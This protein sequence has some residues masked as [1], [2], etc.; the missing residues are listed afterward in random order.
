M[1]Q[2]ATRPCQIRLET[3]KIVTLK[4]GDVIDYAE[5]HPH[6]RPISTAT[7]AVDA[8][9]TDFETAGEDELFEAEYDLEELKHYIKSRYDVPVR[10]KSKKKLIEKLLDCRFRDL[11]VADRQPVAE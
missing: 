3:E 1:K 11:T 6:L 5:E 10:V 7:V 9:Y 4:L 8:A 2:V